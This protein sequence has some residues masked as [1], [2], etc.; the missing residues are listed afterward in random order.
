MQT[1]SGA[2]KNS[3]EFHLESPGQAEFQRNL[4]NAGIWL[5]KAG[6]YQILK[7]NVRNH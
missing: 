1:F 6:D 4:N 2:R 5:S 3:G 7:T